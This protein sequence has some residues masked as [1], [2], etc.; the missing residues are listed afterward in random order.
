M[1]GRWYSLMEDYSIRSL[2]NDMDKLPALSGLAK[3]YQD[4]FNGKYLA[5]IWSTHLPAALL[6]RNDSLRGTKCTPNRKGTESRYLSYIAPT[7]SWAS[8][9]GS[10]SYESQR[11]EESGPSIEDRVQ[12]TPSDCDFGDLKV[13]NMYTL[14]KH[15]DIYGAIKN[16]YLVLSGAL[17][18]VVDSNP[19]FGGF[20]DEFNSGR[21]GV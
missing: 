9:D 7:W 19:Q 15:N 11:L 5:G 13:E 6:W 10:I 2:T 4:I 3:H 1:R 21:R 8:V 14:P 12:E 16:A 20:E 17:L 18:A